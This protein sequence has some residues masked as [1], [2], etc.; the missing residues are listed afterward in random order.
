[1]HQ[2]DVEQSKSLSVPK[3]AKV[4]SEIRSVLELT[5]HMLLVSRHYLQPWP[6]AFL[7]YGTRAPLIKTNN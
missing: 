1:M 4:L 7:P 2:T 3:T 6:I 5:D